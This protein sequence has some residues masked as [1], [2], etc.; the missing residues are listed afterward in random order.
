MTKAAL[1]V[2]IVWLVAAVAVGQQPRAQAAIADRAA[3]CAEADFA[4]IVYLDTDP[5]VGDERNDLIAALNIMLTMTTLQPVIENTIPPKVPETSLLRVDLRHYGWNVDD[6]KE[7]VKHHPYTDKDWPLIVRADWLLVELCDQHDSQSGAYLR[8][9][10][11]GKDAPKSRDDILA[12]LEV[13]NDQAHV[14]GLVEGDSQVAKRK[15]GR[16]IESRPLPRGY[17]YLTRDVLKLTPDKDPIEN[18]ADV[19]AGKNRHDGEEVICM[20]QKLSSSANVRGVMPIYFLADGGGNIVTRAPVDLVEDTFKF[21]NLAEIRYPGACFVSCHSDG[22]NAPTRD[23]FVAI[24]KDGLFPFVNDPVQAAQFQAYFLGNVLKEVERA[25]DDQQTFV[26]L[27]TGMKHADAAAAFKRAVDRYDAPL[28]ML[29]VAEEYTP[30]GWE[31]KD[32]VAAIEMAANENRIGAR[33]AG[34]A[35]NRTIDREAFEQQFLPLFT[36]LKRWAENN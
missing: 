14:F 35:R 20:V 7:V 2:V 33:M 17:C 29:Q 6:W 22:F 15:G 30:F 11:G 28:T 18:L 26:E 24:N 8:L 9:L 13:T 5:W 1:P 34:I 25:N 3:Y 21:R 27:L 4:N 16:V 12:R 32:V 10:F 31:V 19:L 23:E 36:E